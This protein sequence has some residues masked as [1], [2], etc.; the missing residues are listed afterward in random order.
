MQAVVNGK[1]TEEYKAWLRA[2]AEKV[3]SDG[4]TLVSEWN[5]ICCFE[6]DLAT[7]KHKNPQQAFERGSWEAADDMTWPQADKAFWRCNRAGK[8]IWGR[9]RA[10]LRWL[11]VSLRTWWDPEN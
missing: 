3:N 10:D 9:L 7:R 1:Y 5:Q 2:E 8:G 4:C 11:G 6:H